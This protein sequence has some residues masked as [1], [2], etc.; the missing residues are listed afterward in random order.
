MKRELLY[1]FFEGTTSEA[2][3]IE[4][5]GW[6]E[7]SSENKKMFFQERLAY[8]ATL[9]ASHENLSIKKTP[10]YKYVRKI[11]MA[12]A[13]AALIIVN[14][15]YYFNLYVAK[16]DTYN[17]ILVPPGQRINLI[18]SDNSNVWLNANS[19]FKYPTRFSSKN[20]SVYL[21][22]EAYFDVHSNDKSPFIVR[23]NYGDVQATGTSFNVEAYSRLNV[24]ETSLFEGR[25]EV[26]INDVESVVLLP[27]QN[28]RLT[29]G[30]LLVTQITDNDKFLWRNGLI[31][32]NNNKLE[33]IFASLE[34]Y[35]AIK[36]QIDSTLLPEHTYTGKFRQSDGVDYALRVLQKSIKFEFERDDNSGTIQIK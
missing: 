19:T 25:V 6:L 11:S 21:D 1:S 32:F 9:L 15:L 5:R 31:A 13:I 30:Q 29:Q 34:K 16:P 28:S 35:F 2:E 36:I 4:I 8:D 10:L 17:T 24:F 23:T 22:G 18:L 12:A 27:N 26:Q 33:E 20:R 7:A 3:E 14:G